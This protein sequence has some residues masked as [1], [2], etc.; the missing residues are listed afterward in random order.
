MSNHHKTSLKGWRQGKF[1]LEKLAPFRTGE[2][3]VPSPYWGERWMDP[4]DLPA[5]ISST[6]IYV[7]EGL[8]LTHLCG[9]CGGRNETLLDVHTSAPFKSSSEVNEMADAMAL[10][11]KARWIPEHIDCVHAPRVHCTPSVVQDFVGALEGAAQRAVAKRVDLPQLTCILDTAGRAFCFPVLQNPA[12]A[13]TYGSRLRK[14]IRQNKLD[15]LAVVAIGWAQADMRESPDLRPDYARGL[16]I[17]YATSSFAQYG[18]ASIE[19]AYGPK[20]HGPGRV[21]PLHWSPLGHANALVDTI[22]A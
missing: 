5:H 11:A 6:A 20:G 10:S 1:C 13:L 2:S 18:V 3:A 8:L 16:K 14:T 7:P 12:D 21:A 22:L 9:D 17:V 19:Q 15:V 4:S